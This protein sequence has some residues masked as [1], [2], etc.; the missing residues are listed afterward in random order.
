MKKVF[1][2]I[3]EA[4]VATGIKKDILLRAKIH[5]KS[6]KGLTGFHESGR[7][8]WNVA[9]KNLMTLKQ[10]M[11]DHKK[12]LES[13]ST[14]TLEYW[15]LMRLKYQ[16]LKAEAELEQRQRKF[17]S[18]ED[19]ITMLERTADAFKE[20]MNNQLRKPLI[21]HLHL[22]PEKIADLDAMLAEINGVFDRQLE[23]WNK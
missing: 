20:T 4:E 17:V 10:W 1:H 22:T 14:G 19:V 12:E 8:Y 21:E 15:R 3:K 2:G 23:V 5:P 6:P 9:D 16:A 11:A 18:R 7:I 13:V